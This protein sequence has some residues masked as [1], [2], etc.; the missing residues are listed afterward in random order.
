M[1]KLIKE[2]EI[3]EGC[4]SK[5]HIFLA[6]DSTWEKREERFKGDTHKAALPI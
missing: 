6:M 1:F 2:R 3:G 5:E 4:M